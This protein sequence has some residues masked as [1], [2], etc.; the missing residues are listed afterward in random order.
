LRGDSERDVYWER[1]GGREG[2]RVGGREGGRNIALIWLRV[3][4]KWSQKGMV[5]QLLPKQEGA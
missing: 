3:G 4:A 5:M 2:G 1:E